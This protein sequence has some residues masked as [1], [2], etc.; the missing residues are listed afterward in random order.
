MFDIPTF[1]KDFVIFEGTLVPEEK[2]PGGL[3]SMGSQSRTRLTDQVQHKILF[4]PKDP[5][6][7]TIRIQLSFFLMRPIVYQVSCKSLNIGT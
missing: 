7:P 5:T 6:Q 2:Q 4:F 1:P 3:Q